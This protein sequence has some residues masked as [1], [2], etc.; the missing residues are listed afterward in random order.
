MIRFDLIVYNRTLTTPVI[1][2]AQGNREFNDFVAI[3][4]RER[5]LAAEFLY[6]IKYFISF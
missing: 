3:I 1:F 4:L 6:I 2:I 5:S